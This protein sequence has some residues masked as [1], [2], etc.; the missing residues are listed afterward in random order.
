MNPKKIH[1][2]VPLTRVR[3]TPHFYYVIYISYWHCI[4]LYHLIKITMNKSIFDLVKSH[5]CIF[6]T[7]LQNVKLPFWTD[8]FAQWILQLD[9]LAW[10]PDS[11]KLDTYW[12]PCDYDIYRD[13]PNWEPTEYEN[14]YR[15]VE[16]KNQNFIVNYQLVIPWKSPVAILNRFY[17]K[18]REWNSYVRKRRISVYWKALKLYYMWYIPRLFDY[19]NKYS[20]PCCRADLCRDFPC[21]IPNWIIDLKITWTDHTTTYFGEKDSPFMIRTYD[22]TQDLKHQKNCFAWLYPKWYLDKCRRLE[23]QFKGDYS[24]S[25]SVLDWLDVCKV[26]KSVI[27]KIEKGQRNVYKTAL[28]SVI[29]TIDWVNLSTQEKLDILTNSKKLLEN[30]IKKISESLL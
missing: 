10:Y 5:I 28:Y 29:N 15:M 24:R 11:L 12:I 18:V 23:C 9:F 25:M 27:Q 7:N 30:K 20:W 13:N 1:V 26:D 14:V 22:K 19:I 4:I 16:V 3:W 6:D 21:E 2:I 8:K 17:F